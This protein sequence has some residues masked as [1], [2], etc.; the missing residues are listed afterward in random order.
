[1]HLSGTDLEGLP[2]EKKLPPIPDRKDAREV[3]IGRSLRVHATCKSADHG[4]DKNYSH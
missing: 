1:M 4:G 2:V 3:P